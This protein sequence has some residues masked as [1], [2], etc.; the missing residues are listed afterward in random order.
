[1]NMSDNLTHIKDIGLAR[2][3]WLNEHNI[4]TYADL[5][6]TDPNWIC[7]QLKKEGSKPPI[8]LETVQH[9]IDEA[10]IMITT[11]E[12][13]EVFANVIPFQPQNSAPITE[14]GWD[15]FASFYVSYQHKR[16]VQHPMLRTQVIYRTYADHIEA[17]ENNQWEGIEGT[18]LCNWIMNHVDNIIDQ[19]RV[20]EKNDVIQTTV[21]EPE[22]ANGDLTIESIEV[23]NAIGESV[24]GTINTSFLPRAL[25]SRYPVT[26]TPMLRIQQTDEY[27][28]NWQGTL[29]LYI[30]KIPKGHSTPESQQQQL[31]LSHTL[32]NPYRHSFQAVSLSP[33]LYRVQVILSKTSL[34]KQGAT[35]QEYIFQLI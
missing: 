35:L 29:S 9:W 10:N 23:K 24:V 16:Q 2:Q 15:E 30:T 17:N 3:K 18:D 31:Q 34:P 33:G 14:E 22:L 7:E 11:P 27:A 12:F 19:E 13:S 26:I 1:M 32:P 4:H 28:F 21:T 20:Q 6:K 5:A 8:L 25:S